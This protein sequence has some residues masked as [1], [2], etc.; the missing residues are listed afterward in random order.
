MSY[1]TTTV[2]TC[3]LCRKDIADARKNIHVVIRGAGAAGLDIGPC[4]AGRPIADMVAA[5]NKLAG[6]TP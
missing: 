5:A 2:Y 4:C 6:S 3:D 1:R